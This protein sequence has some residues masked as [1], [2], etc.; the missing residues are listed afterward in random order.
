MMIQG[1]VFV[2]KLTIIPLAVIP[3]VT[4]SLVDQERKQN[5]YGYYLCSKETLTLLEFVHGS[6]HNRPPLP[7]SRWL[8]YHLYL[9]GYFKIPSI[10]TISLGVWCSNA[11]ST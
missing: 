1:P 3:G 8:S 9:L 5:C 7:Q 2:T 4:L 11:N 10:T 6:C